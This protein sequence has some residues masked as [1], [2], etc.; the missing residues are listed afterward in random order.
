M[1]LLVLVCRKEDVADIRDESLQSFVVILVQGPGFGVDRG[2]PVA[3]FIVSSCCEVR[4][5]IEVKHFGLLW[6][7]HS[8]SR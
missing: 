8:I 7:C 1:N 3:E 2:V 6:C 4:F 5:P